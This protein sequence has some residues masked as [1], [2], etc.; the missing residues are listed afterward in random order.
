MPHICPS[1][2]GPVFREEG[3]AV[4]RCTNA[5]CPAQ[6]LRHLIHFTSRDAMDIEGMGEKVVEQFFNLKFL[7]SITDIYKIHEHRTEILTLDGWSFK[8]V[9]NLIMAIDK[10]KSNS[11]EKLLFGLGIKEIGE[12]TARMLSKRFVDL[13]KFKEISYEELLEIQDIGPASAISLYDYFH[14]E[15]N[16]KLIEELKE[17]GLNFQY[18]GQAI[19]MNS[20]FSNKTVVLT[21]TLNKYGRKKA[22]EILE[23]LG[24][25]VTGS[26][27]KATD[28]V[29]AGTEAG[30]KLDKARALNIKIMDEEEFLSYI[31]EN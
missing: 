4:L 16:L 1:C 8:S 9:D 31:D 17:L 7:S 5:E 21:G 27:S 22:T 26:V 20:Y 10:S 19:D 6:M 28:I 2:G 11:L 15:D 29:I 23:N 25:K 18:L 3:E 24:A 14:N 12:K 30:S 13:E